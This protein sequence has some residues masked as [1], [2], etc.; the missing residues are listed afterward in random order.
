[1]TSTIQRDRTT[2]LAY[3]MLAFY[4]YCLNSL[5]PL[6]P[7]LKSELDISY[8]VSSLHFTAFAIGIIGA[9]R[10]PVR[11][12]SRKACICCVK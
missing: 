1:M 3:A 6:T 5:G 10:C 7:F 9:A 8:S 4:A 2:W 11:F 12:P